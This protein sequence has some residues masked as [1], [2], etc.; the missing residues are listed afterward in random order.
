MFRNPD[1]IITRRYS[2]GQTNYGN[3]IDPD[4]D[5]LIDQYYASN[6]PNERRELT[7]QANDYAL[8]Q[9]WGVTFPV[10]YSY[11]IIQP[12][13]MG[14]RGEIWKTTKDYGGYWINQKL[15]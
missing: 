6:D 7:K 4:Y 5:K 15:K 8:T 12:W 1:R 2:T 10:Y 14:F 13:I 11:A 9:Y 3:V